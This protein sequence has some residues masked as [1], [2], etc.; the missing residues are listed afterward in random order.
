MKTGYILSLDQKCGGSEVL[1]FDMDGHV[2]SGAFAESTQHCSGTGWL[3]QDP[4][5]ICSTAMRA[6]ADAL[7]V[8]NILPREVRA[9]G[10]T[11]ESDAMVLWESKS[12]RPI[13]RSISQLGDEGVLRGDDLQL[14]RIQKMTREATGQASEPCCFAG[15]KLRWMLDTQPGLRARAERREIA[16]GTLDSWLIYHLTGGKEHITDHSNA[17]RTRLYDDRIRT[18]NRQLLDLLGIPAG[19]LPR[20][21][22]LSEGY[23]ETARNAFFGIQGIPLAGIAEHQKAFL[24]G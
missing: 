12:G 14:R 5:E 18:W 24:F 11:N 1:I 9:I 21:R 7:T 4:D 3:E 2:R 10:I 20:V 6:I 8:G 22:P 16:C 17:L 23:G 13:G 15:Y 19:I